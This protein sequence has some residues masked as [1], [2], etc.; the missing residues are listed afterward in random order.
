MKEGSSMD[1]VALYYPYVSPSPAWL[2]Q[3]LL[4]FEKL[5]SIVAPTTAV[6]S[7]DLGWLASKGVWTPTYVELGYAAGYRDE[8]ETALLEFADND[9][10][11]VGSASPTARHELTRIYTG[12]LAGDLEQ[13]MVDLKLALVDRRSRD[14]LAHRDVAAIVLAITA[15]YVAAAYRNPNSRMVC[16]TDLPIFEKIAYDPLRGSQPRSRCLELLLDGLAPVPGDDVSYPDIIDF[17]ERHRDELGRLRTE[18]ARMLRVIRSSEDPFDEIRSMREEIRQSVTD[19]K[20]AARSHRI[21]LV[22][23]SCSVLALGG[24]A[25]AVLHGETL[26]WVFDGFGVAAIAT[27]MDRL[28]RGRAPDDAFAYLLSAESAFGGSSIAPLHRRRPSWTRGR[29]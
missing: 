6:A 27:L 25:G 19:I 13:S 7:G 8:I 21:R 10:Y 1:Q 28:V 29:R 5:S 9:N 12:K 14:L 26:H 3:S 15:K 22:A 17:R 24:T 20:E 23:G 4:M 16:S 18:V 11:R 2:K